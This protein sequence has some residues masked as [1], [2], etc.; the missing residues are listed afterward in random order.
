MT[1]KI[2]SSEKT[3]LVNLKKVGK[4]VFNTLNQ[5]EKL[6]AELIFCTEEEIQTLNRENRE[7]DAVTDVLSFPTLDGVKGKIISR[8]DYPLEYNK[9]L[10][11]FIGSIAICTKRAFEQA[12]EYGHSN[13]REF[14]FL[15]VHSLLHLLGYDHIEEQDR[16]EMRKLEDAIL[17][18]LKIGV[19]R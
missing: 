18:K 16:I 4:A 15:T 7:K 2:I 12:E 19:N 13:E 17:E 10:G 8:Y 3:S 9:K 11:V 5:K 14:T 6:W 1:I